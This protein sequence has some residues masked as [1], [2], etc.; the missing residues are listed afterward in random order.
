MLTNCHTLILRNLLDHGPDPPPGE[1]DLYLYNVA[2]DHLP[3]ADG[4]RSRETHRFD[5][6]PGA[7]ER[8]PD[9]SLAKEIRLSQDLMELF[10]TYQVPAL[11]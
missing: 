6:P 4:F 7:L 3:L 2:P 10:V 11:P 1:Q 8:L 9:G 5:P